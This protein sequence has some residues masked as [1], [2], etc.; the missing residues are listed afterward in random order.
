MLKRAI[1]L[2]TV[3]CIAMSFAS[4]TL[5]KRSDPT[6]ETKTEEST[7]LA[8]E[9]EIEEKTSAGDLPSDQE[10][11]EN[12]QIQELP[13]IYIDQTWNY[14]AM[15]EPGWGMLGTFTFSEDGTVSLNLMAMVNGGGYG[16]YC[17]GNDTLGEAQPHW[18]R[19]YRWDSQTMTVFFEYRVDYVW[20]Y[21][22]TGYP[23]PVGEN[24]VPVDQTI[25]MQLIAADSRGVRM[26]TDPLPLRADFTC[27]PGGEIY[28]FFEE[29]DINSL[30]P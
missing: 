14:L 22:E 6:R 7:F 15:V 25:T 9:I 21:D 16:W 11:I 5:A 8:E 24:N 17:P 20:E 10:K 18:I 28:L 23:N 26:N 12:E 2:S 3:I 4:C 1:A 19:T 29:N 13:P 30:Y 27:A